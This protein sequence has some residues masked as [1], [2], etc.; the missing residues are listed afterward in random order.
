MERNCY[1][2]FYANVN[3]IYHIIVEHDHN[4]TYTRTLH[5]GATLQDCANTCTCRKCFCGKLVLILFSQSSAGERQ[6]ERRRRWKKKHV[7]EVYVVALRRPLPVN[8]PHIPLHAIWL[9]NVPEVI[10]PL[11][12]PTI[13]VQ[14]D[15]NWQCTPFFSCM[16]A[17]FL[18]QT[19][20]SRITASTSHN[21]NN[22]RWICKI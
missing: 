13:A 14:S 19:I 18:C 21:N 9:S 6:R 20:D 16:H 3:S 2:T 1:T 15:C 22:N 5:A 4:G 12:F 11:E 10:S 17:V 7:S 8:F